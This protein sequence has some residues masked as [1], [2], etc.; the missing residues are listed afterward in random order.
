MWKDPKTAPKTGEVILA[1]LGWPWPCLACWNAA[2]QQWVYANLQMNLVG[3]LNDPYFDNEY[4]NHD[5]L[6]RWAPLPKLPPT[7][8]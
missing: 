5:E 8:R 6:K 1:D 3:G 7:Y 4:G 2:E